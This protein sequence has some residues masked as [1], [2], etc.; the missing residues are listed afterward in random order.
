M[1]SLSAGTSSST[2]SISIV[3]GAGAD[4]LRAH[5]VEERREV[6]DLGFA[7]RVLDDRRAL[8]EHRRAHEVLGRADARELEHDARAV[9]R[10]A[11]RVHE[12]VHD[13]DL[14]AHRLEPAQVHVD[15][16]AADVVAAGQRD[17]RLAA[18]RE[19]RPEHVERRAHAADELVRRL[20]LQRARRV[21]AHDVGLGLLDVGAD[22]AQQVAHHV[23]IEH[24]RHVAQRRDAGREQRR[25]HLLHARVL[26]RA[27]DLDP[28]FERTA[29]AHAEASHGDILGAR[30][31]GHLPL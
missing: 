26:G 14:G 19:Q 7:R 25:G 28:A 12:A 6:G 17:A 29:R 9:Q 22:R 21:D 30:S 13:L 3:D 31:R 16:A 24:R 27:R 8:G 18:A 20:G 2:P 1:I 4:H 23:E 5:A 11:A 15:L 10:V